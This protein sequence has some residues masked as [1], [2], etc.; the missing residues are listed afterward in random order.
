MTANH[1]VVVYEVILS[2][3]RL[4][5]KYG[6][7]LTV[8]WDPLVSVMNKCGPH[9]DQNPTSSMV[10]C[11]QEILSLMDNLYTAGKLFML[12]TQ[13][14]KLLQLYKDY[15]PPTSTLVLIN[16][17]SERAHP[18]YD[19]W[20][21]TL[22]DLM[23]SF[24]QKEA[25]TPV[26]LEALA[27]FETKL[28]SFGALY[29]DV[30]IE[31]GLLPFVH[32]GSSGDDVAVRQQLVRLIGKIGCDVPTVHYSRLLQLVEAATTVDVV[33]PSLSD[34]NKTMIAGAIP[35][36]REVRVVAVGALVDMFV[37]SLVTP[38][39]DNCVATFT[40]LVKLMGHGD[41][42]VRLRAIKC[43][44]SLRATHEYKVRFML[45]TDNFVESPY[46]YSSLGPQPE[47]IEGVPAP[48]TSSFRFTGVL[49]I[50]LFYTSLLKRLKTE[51]NAVRRLTPFT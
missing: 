47:P 35:E 46:L 48:V 3:R 42:T 4:V 25:A 2:L 50:N 49:P 39:I 20:L 24:F 32:H 34:D 51:T 21:D 19:D 13:F 11:V 10:A 8:E 15:L 9:V 12:D 16:Y 26:K 44:M 31:R 17:L 28:W 29:A 30:M 43:L 7:Q 1:T 27:I 23:T 6:E 45:T 41:V 40:S 33:A 36:V 37:S 14:I 22:R 18:A 38:P 5:R